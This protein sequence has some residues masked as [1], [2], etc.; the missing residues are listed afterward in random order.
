LACGL[1]D[2]PARSSSPMS[3]GGACVIYLCA[4]A[5][6]SRAEM[7]PLLGGASL[8]AMV[9]SERI[10]R[11][12]VA[13]VSPGRASVG[14]DIGAIVVDE[15]RAAHLE[16]VR[17]VMVN[18]E[19]E[20]IIQLVRNVATA[21]EADAI[22]LVGGAGLG[23]RDYACEAVDE[24]ADRHIEGFGE[25]YRRLLRDDDDGS[26]ATAVLTRAA[27][28]TYNGCVVVAL[29]RQTVPMMRRAVQKLLVP[30]LPR[31]ARIAAGGG[32]I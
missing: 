31:A 4:R 6:R 8:M 2:G 25:E 12:L 15:L 24:M 16:I 10:V 5:K 9:T 30:I 23:P 14:D 22:V 7:R 19:K 32:H 1:R 17:S 27:A 29:P 11:C 13:T 20:Y 18:R 26:V 28:A 21:N 3:R